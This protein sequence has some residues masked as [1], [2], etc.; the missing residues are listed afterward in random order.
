[1]DH[2]TPIH[3][4][5]ESNIHDGQPI[6]GLA[7]YKGEQG[8][9]QAVFDELQDE[10][11]Y[12]RRLVLYELTEEELADEWHRHRAWEVMGST[13]HCHHADVPAAPERSEANLSEFYAKYP[14][15]H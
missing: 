5:W 10:W 6:S 12:P 11:E 9:F 7:E 14:P 15:R 13:K 4:L 1:M 8:C 2:L 3:I